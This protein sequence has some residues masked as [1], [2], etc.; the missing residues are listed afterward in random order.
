MVPGGCHPALVCL[1][2]V[3]AT[4]RGRVLGTGG[5]QSVCKAETVGACAFGQGRSSCNQALQATAGP[6]VLRFVRSLV[7]L[8][9]VGVLRWP[10]APERQ[11]LAA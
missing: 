3:V 11:P 1:L 4:V 2:D 10:A 8:C 6:R 5:F 7:F 9:I